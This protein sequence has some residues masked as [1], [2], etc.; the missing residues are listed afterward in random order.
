MHFIWQRATALYVRTQSSMLT[1]SDNLEKD[2]LFMDTFC[3]AD[4][5]SLSLALEVGPFEKPLQEFE[6]DGTVTEKRENNETEKR[7]N[8]ETEKRENIAT[9]N[10]K[11]VL[12]SEEMYDFFIKNKLFL[13]SEYR[14]TWYFGGF[15]ETK[16]F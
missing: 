8:S 3:K 15:N 4:G 12:Q 7:E 11:V 5:R 9:Q 2:L 1:M 10:A 14:W 13:I 6:R 16:L